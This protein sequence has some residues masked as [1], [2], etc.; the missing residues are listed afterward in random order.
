MKQHA[1]FAAPAELTLR[2]R[3]IKRAQASAD[4]SKMDSNQRQFRREKRRMMCKFELDDQLCKG[5]VADISA[6]GMFINSTKKPETGSE[7]EIILFEDFSGEVSIRCRVAR[8]RNSHG[9]AAAVIPA[10]FGVVIDYAPEAFFDL[11]VDIGLG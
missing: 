9:S 8:L 11:L 7:I 2:C 10:G 1:I 3:P 4:T 5:I 6:R